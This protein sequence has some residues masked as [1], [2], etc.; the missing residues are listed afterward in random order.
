MRLWTGRRRC[1]RPRRPARPDPRG[2]L[3]LGDHVGDADAVAGLEDAEGLGEH[4]WL[5]GGEVDH[6]VGDDH[7]DRL[8]RQGDGLD[9]APLRKSTFPASASAALARARASISSVM[10]SP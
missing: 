9:L 2:E 7:V 10:S 8:G 1:S 5:V 6:A 4:G 3:I